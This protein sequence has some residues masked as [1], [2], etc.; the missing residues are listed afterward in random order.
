MLEFNSSI[1]ARGIAIGGCKNMHDID[2]KLPLKCW[3]FSS[4]IKLRIKLKG[5]TDHRDGSLPSY[6]LLAAPFS[7]FF[8]FIDRN[9][10][11]A[12]I[13][14]F[15]THEGRKESQDAMRSHSL[16]LKLTS[17]PTTPGIRP[18]IWQ[19][20]K[21]RLWRGRKGGWERAWKHVFPL[22]IGQDEVSR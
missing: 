6:L 3:N 12:F 21:I 1:R 5:D 15:L 20:E 8:P 4:I 2:L 14:L 19:G 22:S 10:A 16:S 7:S 18:L 11:A 9:F 13:P 17:S